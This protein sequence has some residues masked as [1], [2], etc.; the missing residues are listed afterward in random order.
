MSEVD[1]DNMEELFGSS[2]YYNIGE[3]EEFEF[4]VLSE[5]FYSVESGDKDILGNTAKYDKIEVL[6][7]DKNDTEYALKIHKSL[8]RKMVSFLKDNDKPLKNT[9]WRV[10]R[11]DR[12]TYDSVEYISNGDSKSATT[13]EEKSIDET[14]SNRACQLLTPLNEAPIDE[15]GIDRFL[16]TKLGLTEKK[17]KELRTTLIKEKKIQTKDGFLYI[18]GA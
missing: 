12:N 17:A 7:K 2:Q 8:G 18:E 6:V 11:S 13:K 10:H 3:D 15:N 1:L 5:K 14:I 16:S 4:I 9:K